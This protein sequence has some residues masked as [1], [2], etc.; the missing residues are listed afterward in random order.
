MN[1]VCWD[2]YY[3]LQWLPWHQVPAPHPRQVWELWIEEGAQFR[4][5]FDCIVSM[6]ANP[7]WATQSSWGS[8]SSV[9]KGIKRFILQSC[10][11]WRLNSSCQEVTKQRV[12]LPLFCFY[13]SP[14]SKKSVCFTFMTFSFQCCW[15]SSPMWKHPSLSR[16][17]TRAAWYDLPRP[18]NCLLSRFN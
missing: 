18:P 16:G 15:E 2:F 6:S 3:D 1:L 5:E 17:W 11:L 4:L 13:S 8:L 7:K 14:F 10:S 9:G 12:K